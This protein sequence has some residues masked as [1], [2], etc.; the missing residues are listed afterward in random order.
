MFHTSHL[1][2]ECNSFQ[3][4]FNMNVRDI[5]ACIFPKL[6]FWGFYSSSYDVA[7]HIIKRP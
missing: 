3:L 7:Y 4:P 6:F 5:S 2:I 1:N